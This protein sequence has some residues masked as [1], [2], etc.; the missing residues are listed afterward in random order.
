MRRATNAGWL[1]E[2]LVLHA[3]LPNQPSSPGS[4]LLRMRSSRRFAKASKV[5]PQA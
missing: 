5:V 4:W 2:A 3:T 1:P